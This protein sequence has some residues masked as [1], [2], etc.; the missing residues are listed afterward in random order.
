MAKRSWL[1]LLG[2]A[3]FACALG[4]ACSDDNGDTDQEVLPNQGAGGT[5]MGA[6]GAG[7]SAG[8]GMGGSANAGSS[9]GAG[10]SGMSDGAGGT[11][12]AGVGGSGMGGS[13]AAP[14]AAGSGMGGSGMG[15]AGM[16]PPPEEEPEE[17]EPPPA[18]EG[19]SFAEDVQPI[20]A[21]SCSPCHTTGRSGGHSVGSD[22]LDVA[23]ADAQRLGET[24]VGR[25]DGGGM[26]PGCAV[27]G[28][29]PCI[30]LD[31]LAIV[32]AWVEDP[33]P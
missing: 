10:G 30:S 32:E 23:L 29:A 28:Q 31:E 17:E 2:G 19:V 18:S 25:L 11:A 3:A 13:A 15:G 22:D 21:E 24:L 27:A 9:A 7:G 1:R 20:F 16:E 5:A 8:A 12:M 26:P 14:G 6:A 33:Q 4:V